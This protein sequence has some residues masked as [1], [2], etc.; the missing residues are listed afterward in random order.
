ME[1][2]PWSRQLCCCK[3][4]P[5]HDRSGRRQD[6]LS[7]VLSKDLGKESANRQVATVEPKKY[8]TPARRLIFCNACA[9]SAGGSVTL[10][11]VFSVF[12]QFYPVMKLKLHLCLNG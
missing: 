11:E 12:L 5:V 6:Q 7:N 1:K 10:L 9:F 3:N 2:S 8:L 4:L